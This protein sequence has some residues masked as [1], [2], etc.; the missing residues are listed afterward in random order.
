MQPLADAREKL[1]WAENDLQPLNMAIEAFI[2]S[3]PYAFSLQKRPE[4]HSYDLV[5]KV[6]STIP[7]DAR[8]L[9]SNFA[10]DARSALDLAVHECAR[11][12]KQ[13]IK[14]IQ[15]PIY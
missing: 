9:I 14:K 7:T 10:G 15:L 5:A 4:P 8:R 1:G 2:N 3:N 12:R 13:K 11:R 6:S